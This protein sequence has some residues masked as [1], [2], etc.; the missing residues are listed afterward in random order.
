MRTTDQ[1]EARF[2]RQADAKIQPGEQFLVCMS[3][4]QLRMLWALS[5]KLNSG[6]RIGPECFDM[7]HRLQAVLDT[8]E[9]EPCDVLTV[10]NVL[11]D[12]LEAVKSSERSSEKGSERRTVIIDRAAVSDV[13]DEQSV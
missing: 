3:R 6:Q 5:M 8:I 1:F 13:G 2:H 9:V 7:G 12:E 10:G 11:T 4:G